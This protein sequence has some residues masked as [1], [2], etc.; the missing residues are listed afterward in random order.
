MTNAVVRMLPLLRAQAQRLVKDPVAA[1][2]LVEK[3]LLRALCEV[4]SQIP[5]IHIEQ[6]L[7]ALMDAEWQAARSSQ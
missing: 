4:E 7:F 1:D 5:D 3:T 6:W 2:A